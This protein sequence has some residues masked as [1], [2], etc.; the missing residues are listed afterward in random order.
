MPPETS[1]ISCVQTPV[2]AR[3]KKSNTVGLLPKL[4]L[5]LMSTRPVSVLVL[6]VKSG[7]DVPVLRGMAGNVKGKMLKVQREKIKRA[8]GEPPASLST[9]LPLGRLSAAAAAAFAARGPARGRRRRG[10]S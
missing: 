2:K 5:S 3:G 8:A 9:F 4:S 1:H 10:P 7:A 6:R